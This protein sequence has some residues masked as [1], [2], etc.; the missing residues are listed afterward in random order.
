MYPASDFANSAVRNFDLFEAV[1]SSKSSKA[2][3]RHHR[4]GHDLSDTAIG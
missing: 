3:L 1:M 2:S 4:S